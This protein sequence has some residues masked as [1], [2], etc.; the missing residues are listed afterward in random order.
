MADI[1]RPIYFKSVRQF[2]S[3]FIFIMDIRDMAVSSN[4][5]TQESWFGIPLGKKVFDHVNLCFPTYSCLLSTASRP[6]LGP[7]QLLI[8][9]VPWALSQGVKRSGREADRSPATSAEIKKT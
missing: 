1:D 2:I 7:T 8:R 9:R 6:A 4:A 3:S 5:C